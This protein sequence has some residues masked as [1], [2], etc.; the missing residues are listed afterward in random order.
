MGHQLE[1]MLMECT[2]NNKACYAQNFTQFYS[3]K[4]G[5]CFTLN[6]SGFRASKSGPGA[7]LDMTLDIQTEEYI[8]TF[9][10]GY[11][12][13]VVIHENGTLPFPGTEGV[14]LSAGAE[15]HVILKLINIQRLSGK[16]GVCNVSDEFKR[17]YGIQYS[18]KAC[19][20]L[21][22]RTLT[23]SNCSCQPGQDF[24]FTFNTQ[25]NVK[26]CGTPKEWQ[27]EDK[28]YVGY[29]AD[30]TKGKNPCHCGAACVQKDF[31]TRITTR[32]WPLL[33]HVV[34][35]EAQICK[36][37]D[38]VH[39]KCEY[40]NWTVENYVKRKSSFVRIRVYYG[41]LNYE[42]ITETPEYTLERFLSDIG[43]TLGLWIGCSV[44]S[45]VEVVEVL[46]EVTFLVF[47]KN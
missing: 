42:S 8:E 38:G 18:E 19:R 36:N 25:V 31:D 47:K 11:G 15:S 7:G 39:A 10:T 24:T 9:A 1:K 2:L 27:C 33:K 6:P 16:Y 20:E 43:G 35:L 4:H 23:I 21:C 3:V 5:N 26:H 22:L 12:V 40:E 32:D 13:K 45:L 46:M 30:T 37:N 34:T 14:M 28:V 44:L 29:I 41:T 17:L